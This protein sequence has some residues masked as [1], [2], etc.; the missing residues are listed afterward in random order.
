LLFPNLNGIARKLRGL[1]YLP[2]AT[3]LDA[4]WG[5]LADRHHSRYLSNGY[6]P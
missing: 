2:Y 6:P 5:E 4:H 1:S 3:A